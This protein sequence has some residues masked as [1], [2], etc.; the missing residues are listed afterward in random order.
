MTNSTIASA[1]AAVK[2]VSELATELATVTPTVETENCGNTE[3][4]SAFTDAVNSAEAAI[5]LAMDDV[6]GQTLTALDFALEELRL[7][8]QDYFA[9]VSRNRVNAALH[10]EKAL[11]YME[12]GPVAA[13]IAGDESDIVGGADAIVGRAHLRLVTDNGETVH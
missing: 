11:G 5:Q 7:A 12:T 4:N 8:R 3:D 2:A 10:A 13:T 1:A 6:C 9:P